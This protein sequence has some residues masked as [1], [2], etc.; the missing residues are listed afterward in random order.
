MTERMCPKCPG[1]ALRTAGRGGTPVLRCYQCHGMWVTEAEVA[2]L[3]AEG[4]VTD[5]ASMLPQKVQGDARAGLC[6]EG[7]GILARARVETAEPFFLDRCPTC[8]GIWFDG[9]E[10][11]RLSSLHLER[12]LADLWD[13]E[14]RR[15]RHA[16]RLEEGHRGRMVA[17]VGGDL[18][19]EMD[20]ILDAVARSPAPHEAAG[21]LS[22][23]LESLRRGR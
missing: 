22:Q 15:Q 14:R 12:N 1:V 13:P 6:P 11:Q 2:A 9:G 17:L 8:S 21:Y 18:V 3:A 10:W 4:S 16:A 20:A 19:A 5:P 7:H 23:R